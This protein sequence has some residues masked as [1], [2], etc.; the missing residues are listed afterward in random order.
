MFNSQKINTDPAPWRCVV[1]QSRADDP[2]AAGATPGGYSYEPRPKFDNTPNPVL[3]AF[4]EFD[5][6]RA[7]S[8]TG[9]S[10]TLELQ[11]MAWDAERDAYAYWHDL[12]EIPTHAQ[13]THARKV[14]ERLAVHA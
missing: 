4:R 1:D 5:A 7:C 3:V 11:R 14:L 12:P 2:W 10:A 8:T 6:A 13:M 9:H